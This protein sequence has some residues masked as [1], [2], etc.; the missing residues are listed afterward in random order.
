MSLENC[1]LCQK[2][3]P[4]PFK[5]SGRQVCSGCGWSSK[6]N[7]MASQLEKNPNEKVKN[8]SIVLFNLISSLTKQQLMIGS[9]AIVSIISAYSFRQPRIFWEKRISQ[10]EQEAREL[11]GALWIKQDYVYKKTGKYETRLKNLKTPDSNMAKYARKNLK[12]YKIVI[13]HETERLTTRLLPKYAGLK[14][15]IQILEPTKNGIGILNSLVCES[16][17]PANKIDSPAFNNHPQ[18]PN[19]TSQLNDGWIDDF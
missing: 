7:E 2:Q 4:P 14:S 10:Q 16:I 18:C 12:D 3:L 15:F 6:S 5:S 8:I 13:N 9:L 11:T 1:P 19:G 17:K